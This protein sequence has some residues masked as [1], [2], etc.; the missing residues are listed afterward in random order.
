VL[1]QYRPE[2]DLRTITFVCVLAL[3]VHPSLV[4]IFGTSLSM[5]Q[6]LFRSAVL[7]SAMAP[8]FNAYI[9]ASMYGRGKRIAAS[10]VLI[11][12]RASLLTVWLWLSVLA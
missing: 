7:T 11:A 5:P 2:G 8:G 6:D 4:W 1:V 3:M 12:T 10:S 9:F